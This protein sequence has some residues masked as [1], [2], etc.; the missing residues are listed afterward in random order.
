M[1]R[2]PEKVSKV[3]PVCRPA[4]NGAPTPKR[5]DLKPRVKYAPR[6]ELVARLSS[7]NRG[8][9]ET[10]VLRKLSA[11]TPGLPALIDGPAHKSKLQLLWFFKDRF[12]HPGVRGAASSV[13]LSG[14]EYDPRININN[15]LVKS[16]KL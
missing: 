14:L 11:S 9:T 13:T 1:K 2:S 15:V 12:A 6:S 4:T 3:R 16:S 10:S 8:E 5:R 7:A